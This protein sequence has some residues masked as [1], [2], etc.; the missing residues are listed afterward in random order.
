MQ[1]ISNVEINVKFL[2]VGCISLGYYKHNTS[3]FDIGFL[4]NAEKQEF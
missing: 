4:Q 2:L 1:E 3:F